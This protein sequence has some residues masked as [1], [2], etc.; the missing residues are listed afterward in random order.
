MPETIPYQ[1]GKG[2]ARKKRK[3]GHGKQKIQNKKT[4]L[5]GELIKIVPSKTYFFSASGG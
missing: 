3:K 2:R 4:R 5:N 1:R